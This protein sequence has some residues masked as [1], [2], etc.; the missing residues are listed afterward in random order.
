MIGNLLATERRGEWAEFRGGAMFE[1]GCHLVDPLI[2]LLGQ[3]VDVKPMLRR[4]G[5]IDDDLKDNNAVVFEF[6]SAL[7][8]ITIQRISRTRLRSASFEVFARTVPRF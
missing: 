8:V 5:A 7:G 3:P 1:L 6:P 2:R 4:H